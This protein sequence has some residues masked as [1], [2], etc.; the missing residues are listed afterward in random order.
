MYKYISRNGKSYDFTNSIYGYNDFVNFLVDGGYAHEDQRPTI[1]MMRLRGMI[2]ILKQSTQK[3]EVAQ[4]YLKR[5]KSIAKESHC[6]SRQVGA[7]VVNKNGID[8]R[9]GYNGPP[10]GFPHCETRH[11]EGLKECPRRYAAKKEGREFRSGENLHMCPAVHAER[12][13][14][15]LAAQTHVS[16]NETALYTNEGFSCHDCAKEMVQAGIKEAVFNTFK[17]YSPIE[18]TIRALDIFYHGKVKLYL[19]METEL[20]DDVV[21]K[22][23]RE[24]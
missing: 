6:Y 22:A 16:T 17:E 19:F 10:R 5:A 11:P 14:I 2:F 9:T 23:E 20:L 15:C 12:N 24:V 13:T 4:R 8:I 3:W 7:I 21:K 18:G 1:K